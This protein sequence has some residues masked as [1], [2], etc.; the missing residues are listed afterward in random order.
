MTDYRVP[1]RDRMVAKGFY[2]REI[3][4]RDPLGHCTVTIRA[5]IDRT[6]QMGTWKAAKA[7]R[8]EKEIWEKMPASKKRDLKRDIEAIDMLDSEDKYMRM[9]AEYYF[10]FTPRTQ[11]PLRPFAKVLELYESAWEEDRVMSINRLA[12]A[13]GLKYPSDVSRLYKYFGMEPMT[14]NRERKALE[15]WKIKAIES[16]NGSTKFSKADIAY[17]LQVPKY[18][19]R[20]RLRDQENREPIF[21]GRSANG[22]RTTFSYRD[23]SRVFRMLNKGFSLRYVSIRLD[24]GEDV[25]DFFGKNKKKLRL[26]IVEELSQLL[27]KNIRKPYLS[28][29]L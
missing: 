3:V 25:L 6:D 28:N 4:E 15:K 24:L 12:E 29:G 26:E 2:M 11:Y 8:R 23:A 22:G 17:F 7:K 19:V 1:K 18:C 16:V 21:K 5:Y 9:A 13:T 14:G 10:S 27:G 20:R